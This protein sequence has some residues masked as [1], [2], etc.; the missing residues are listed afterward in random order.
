MREVRLKDIPH[1]ISGIYKLTFP[2]GKS[3]IGQSINIKKRVQEHNQRSRKGRV[4]RDIQ[5][6]EKAI[7]K[8]GEI[9]W[10][11][12]LEEN[13]SENL[14]DKREKYWIQYYNTLDKNKGY[15]LLDH[16]DV[17]GRRGFDNWNSVLT[18]ELLNK[19]INDILAYPNKSLKQI[20]KE[21]NISQALMTRIN[22]GQSYKVDSFTYPLRDPFYKGH[23]KKT[24]YDYFEN[25]EDIYRLK[26][27]ILHDWWLSLEEDIPKK[28]NLPKAIV[29]KINHGE[30]Y[31][32]Y[33]NYI[34]PIRRKN[35][36]PNGL[37]KQ[38]VENILYQLR[39]TSLS[40]TEIGKEYNRGRAFI[41]KINKGE[42]LPIKDYDYPAR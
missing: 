18:P 30:I 3:Y 11:I 9:D 26:D 40:M 17:S 6:C 21:Y 41:S 33:G 12:I 10:F 23:N 13:I 4:D 28:F 2:N 27:T 29:R 20:G 25:E 22:Q 38:D 7:A 31:S 39:N 35:I 32:E 14:L 16:G 8:Y 19:I 36:R 5:L 37:S 42:T 1:G 34:Y 24:F 15:N